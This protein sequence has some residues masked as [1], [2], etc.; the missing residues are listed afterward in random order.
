MKYQEKLAYRDNLGNNRARG[1]R[2]AKKSL[3]V[4]II[5]VIMRKN[6][7]RT[8]NLN[9]RLVLSSILAISIQS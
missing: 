2:N 1:T 7:N 5:L 3:R 9:C 8:M 6:T 4:E